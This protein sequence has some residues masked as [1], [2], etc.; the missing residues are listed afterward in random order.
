MAPQVLRVAEL[1]GN[2]LAGLLERFGLVLE[3]VG[4]D[5]AI[6]GSYWGD[7]EAGIVARTVYARPDTPVHSVLHEASHTICMTRERRERLHTD[8]GGDDLEEIAACY[9]QVLL[10]DELEGVGRERL[11]G[12]MDVWGYNFRLGSAA[13]WFREDAKDARDWLELRG[14]IDATDAPRFIVRV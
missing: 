8:A 5:A 11:L 12:D 1:R 6:P 3:L 10:A 2:T 4:P 9:L 14:L 7:C 13:A